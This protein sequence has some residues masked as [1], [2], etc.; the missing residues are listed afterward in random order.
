MA[1][2]YATRWHGE[3]LV[4]MASPSRLALA[5]P[6]QGRTP[7]VCPHSR[8]GAEQ[9]GPAGAELDQLHPDELRRHWADLGEWV[10]WFVGRYQLADEVPPCWPRHPALVD[11]LIA[12]WYYHQEVTR[13]SIRL[14]Q[15][16]PVGSPS[17]PEE[18]DVPARA[19]WEWHEPRSRW[20]Q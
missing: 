9:L 6:A 13:P 2:L 11:E 5:L 1:P 17:A 3:G 7:S 4:A 19:Y 15:P 18:P 8:R 16:D 14:V 20:V 12:L 10:S